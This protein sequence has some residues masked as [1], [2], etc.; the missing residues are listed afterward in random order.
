M[1]T[2]YHH[3]VLLS[4]NLGTLTSW[5]PLDPSSPDQ[6]R[7]DLP[8]PFTTFIGRRNG[9][10]FKVIFLWD[11]K[12]TLCWGNTTVGSKTPKFFWDIFI[13]LTL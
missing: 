8:L 1:L 12:C 3:P 9:T 6:S 2:I 5:K 13:G 10:M 4:R 11:I 7:T